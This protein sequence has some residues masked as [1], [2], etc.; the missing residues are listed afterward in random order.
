M[1]FIAGAI[2]AIVI[3]LREE[4][5]V[6]VE[7]SC[8]LVGT[9]FLYVRLHVVVPFAGTVAVAEGFGTRLGATGVGRSTQQSVIVN[10]L[11]ILMFGYMITR[12]FYR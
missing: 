6:V 7:T 11:L 5:G 2:V 9:A 1:K 10:F 12:V 3:Y 8:Q 4:I